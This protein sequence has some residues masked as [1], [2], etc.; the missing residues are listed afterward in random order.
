LR[1]WQIARSI[2]SSHKLSCLSVAVLL[3]GSSLLVLPAFAPRAKASPSG[4]SISLTSSTGAAVTSGPPGTIMTVNGTGFPPDSTEV[5]IAICCQNIG[6]LSVSSAPFYC[7]TDLSGSTFSCDYGIL[8]NSDAVN[9]ALSLV[10]GQ[11]KLA[12]GK[13]SCVEDLVK[14]ALPISPGSYTIQVTGEVGVADHAISTLQTATAPFEVTQPSLSLSSNSGPPGSQVTITGSGF[15]NTDTTGTVTLVSD[16]M[17]FDCQSL[18]SIFTSTTCINYA[19]N[20][21]NFFSQTTTASCDNT[22]ASNVDQLSTTCPMSQGNVPACTITMPSGLPGTTYEVQLAGDNPCDC[23]FAQQNY[24]LGPSLK[25]VPNT[26]PV[27]T[28]VTVEG[29]NFAGALNGAPDQAIDFGLFDGL[30][31][32]GENDCPVTQGSFTC[33]FDVPPLT[34]QV[35]ENTVTVCGDALDCVSST[36]TLT[37]PGY[38]M[39][40]SSG[41]PGTK[42]TITGSG[43]SF[44]DT[45]FSIRFGNTNVTPKSNPCPVS[46]PGSFTCTFDVPSGYVSETFVYVTGNTGDTLDAFFPPYFYATEIGFFGLPPTPAGGDVTVTAVGYSQADA[47]S[48]LSLDGMDVT[49][50]GGCPQTNGYM[51][52]TITVPQI[53]PGNYQLTMTGTTTGDSGSVELEVNPTVS[54]S[55]TFGPSGDSVAITGGGFDHLDTSASLT[56]NGSPVPANC[57]VTP[58]GAVGTISCSFAPPPENPGTYTITAKGN[59]GNAQDVVSTSFKI[60]VPYITTTPYSSPYG[61]TVAVTATGF[62]GGDSSATLSFGGATAGFCSKTGPGSFSCSFTIPPFTQDAAYQVEVMGSTGDSA[63]TSYTVTTA[64]VST[65]FV[66]GPAGLFVTVNSAGFP[67]GDQETTLMFGGKTIGSPDTCPMSGGSSSEGC[68]F[69]IPS[70]S[71]G[72]YPLCEKDDYGFIACIPFEVTV[73]QDTVTPAAGPA[74]TTVTVSGTGF[75]GSSIIPDICFGAALNGGTTYC[76]FPLG[77]TGSCPLTNGAFSCSFQFPQPTPGNDAP[78]GTYGINIAQSGFCGFFGSCSPPTPTFTVTVPTISLSQTSGQTGQD[79]TVTGTGFSDAD[80]SAVVS[81]DG[82][83]VAPA[84]EC[85]MASGGF[86]C[87]FIVPSTPTGSHTV[88]ALGDTGDSGSTGFTEVAPVVSLTASSGPAGTAILVSGSGFSS[89]DTT[90]SSLTLGS[91]TLATSG[92]TVSGGVLAGCALVVPS[93]PAG[94]F[95]I[96]AVGGPIGDSASAQFTVTIP[97]IEVFPTSGPAGIPVTVT[98]AGLSF[99]D[100]SATITLN[101]VDVTPAGGCVA[102]AISEGSF[103]CIVTVPPLDDGQYTVTLTGDTLHDSVSALFTVVPTIA[104]SPRSADAGA[105]V[106]VTGS[107]FAGSDSSATVTVGSFPPN[108]CSV[109]QGSVSCSFVAPASNPGSYPVTV[110]GS[111]GD[112]ATAT[113]ILLDSTISLTPSSGPS[114]T[115]V[116]ITGTGFPAVES[117]A[118]VAL[119]TTSVVGLDAS[120]TSSCPIS[121]FGDLACAFVVPTTPSGQYSVTVDDNGIGTAS[122]TFTVTQAS[123]SLS[124]TSG[125]AGSTVVVTGTGF[126]PQDAS[127]T[128]TFGDAAVS[129]TGCTI[130]AGSLAPCTFTVPTDAPGLY[131]VA[132]TGTTGDTGSTSFKVTVASV[133]L[134]PSSGPSGLVIAVSGSGFSTEDTTMTLTFNGTPGYACAASGGY[135][136]CS[137]PVPALATGSYP[138]TVTGGTGDSASAQFT[139]TVPAITLSPS[140]GP[141]GTSVTVTG[142]GYPDVADFAAVTFGSVAVVSLDPAGTSSCPVSNA[143]AIS[144]TFVVPNGATGPATVTVGDFQVASASATFA[145]TVPGIVLSPSTGSPGSQTTVAGS[146]FAGSD[147]SATITFGGSNLNTGCSVSGGAF[148]CLITVPASFGAGSDTVTATGDSGNPADSASATFAIKFPAVVSTSLSST[149][150]SAGQSVTDGA[151]ITIGSSPT[152][153]VSFYYSTTNSCPTAGATQVGDTSYPLSGTSAASGSVTF[154]TPGTYYWYA[155]YS[156]DS[157]NLGSTSPCEPLVVQATGISVTAYSVTP[158][159][160]VG[161]TVSVSGSIENT[162]ATT[163]S[164]LTVTDANAGLLSCLATSLSPG[165]STTCT[166][167]YAAPGTAQIV[168]DSIAATGTD[169]NG[170]TVQAASGTGSTSVQDFALASAPPTVT[171]VEGTS[172]TATISLNNLGGFSGTVALSTPSVPSGLTVSLSGATIAGTVTSTLTFSSSVAGTY[173]LTIVGASG[174]LTRTATV[175]I[176]VNYRD[177]STIVPN[178]GG[179]NLKGADLDYCN[180]AGYDMSGDNLMGASMQ[181]TNLQGANLHGANMKSVNLADSNLKDANLQAANLMGATLKGDTAQ[182]ADFQGS[183]LMGVSLQKGDYSGANFQGANMK[184]DDLSYGNFSSAEFQGANLMD[185]N[186]SYGDFDGANFTGAN[187]NGVD[188]TGATFVGATSPP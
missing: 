45:S 170:A 184:G 154:S 171:I 179:A 93:F 99:A 37:N 146:G 144:C 27:G 128:I 36:F 120:G 38:S 135:L 103:T 62:S 58:A 33:S 52:C 106:T 56:F 123:I 113:F 29:S 74:G 94:T 175:T 20:C 47:T 21:Q 35:G 172:G 116:L 82:S 174:P 86:S 168:T 119:G 15:A 12:S 112:S 134:F 111:S 133:S 142:S 158:A 138:V 9:C 152:G 44:A 129:A 13:V 59:N 77:D 66:L 145:V 167:A 61:Q 153:T 155:V 55:P 101:G 121:G 73:E 39:N 46:S 151:T 65:D 87:P 131:T 137:T 1:K 136:L 122:A 140:S 139:V 11:P 110:K 149:T 156:G 163:V 115:T 8:W 78:P 108:P 2:P 117:F 91:T 51:Q 100:T 160:L 178:H 141:V 104:V 95:A 16:A 161:G 165:S 25:L 177:C 181:Y 19:F 34:G 166:G 67:S 114:G 90:I 17:N 18:T 57:P 41:P 143:G 157:N 22:F 105:T 32:L 79:V 63:S 42:V 89:S 126:S 107:G 64:T 84:S 49:P 118:S 76:S 50:S 186:M 28:V 14:S 169:S 71:P 183:N 6:G 162:G 10:P 31:V 68:A 24:L 164:G 60:T 48:T 53:A 98:V 127:A 4:P 30:P 5:E 150:I 180:L 147:T 176:V 92:C 173:Y 102:P 23:S 96:T 132:A 125:P 81:F 43:Y 40:P 185:S 188:T 69:N 182:N 124:A 80:T 148:S 3:L 159:V 75:P 83:L 26:G 70:V 187:T 130:V 97:S 54:V 109:T 72:T 85:P 88:S 7:P